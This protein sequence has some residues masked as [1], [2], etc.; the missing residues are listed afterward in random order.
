MADFQAVV[1]AVKQVSG[2]AGV[3]IADANG[4]II[5]NDIP[6]SPPELGKVSN[7]VFS[8]ISVQIKRMERGTV[9]RLVLETENGITLISGLSGGEMLVVFINSTDGFNLSDLLEVVARF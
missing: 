5:Q 6:D 1:S 3:A 4:Q 2:V 8:N 9:K 7:A